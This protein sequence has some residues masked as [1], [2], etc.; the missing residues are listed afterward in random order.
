MHAIQGPSF[1][2]SE[3]FPNLFL[4]ILTNP[5]LEETVGVYISAMKVLILRQ[6]CGHGFCGSETS[7]QLW[8]Y[9]VIVMERLEAA[10]AI[11]C[12]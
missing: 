4:Q 8:Y 1:E 6:I 12:I 11:H 10:R 7:N 5:F 3:C 2:G 9:F